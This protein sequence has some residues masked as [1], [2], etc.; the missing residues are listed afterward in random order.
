MKIVDRKTFIAMPANT[1]FSKYEPCFFG[2]LEIKGE[3]I[4]EIDFYVQQIADAV[5]ANN[6]EEFS[7]I[8]FDAEENKASF[9]MD[10]HCE[11]RD[12]LFDDNQLFAVWEHDDVIALI[13]RLQKLL[14]M[15]KGESCES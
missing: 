15:N 6:T 11:G 3:S 4:G 5:D 13:E 1:L 8:L 14:I 2:P 7:E 9:K 10:L 12:G